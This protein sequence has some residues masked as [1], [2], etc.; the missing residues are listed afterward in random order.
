MRTL[1]ALALVLIVLVVL[2]ASAG[3]SKP[4]TPVEAIKKVNEEV[5]V[6][7]LVK[8]AKNRLEKRGEIYLDSEENFRDEKNLGIV[9]TKTGAANFKDAGVN[10]PAE[11]FQDKI[12]RVKGTVIIKEQRP[13]IEVDDPKQIQIVKAPDA[14]DKKAEPNGGKSVNGLAAS[15]E[16]VERTPAKDPPYLEVLFTLKNVSE[17]PITI[18]DYVGNQPLKV[19]WIGPDGKMQKSDHYG[20]LALADLAPLSEKNFVIIPAGGARRLGPRGENSGIAF[21]PTAEKPSRFGN[22]TKPGKHQVTVS[23]ANAEDGKKFNRQNVW[24]GTVTAN[25]LTF[26]VK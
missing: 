5:S 2:G 23:H 14:K 1:T 9:I 12:I 16:V 6:Q 4:I 25:E 19:Q 17:K 13:R 10:D 20:W 8:A 18:C 24:T 11:H 15:A 21:Q 3:E 22:V 26:T 7:M